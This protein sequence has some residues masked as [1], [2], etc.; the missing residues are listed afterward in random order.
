MELEDIL[1]F[2]G[3]VSSRIVWII[4]GSLF[5][6]FAVIFYTGL[7]TFPV[8]IVTALLLYRVRTKRD[9]STSPE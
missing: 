5:N 2:K 9:F 4:L 3:W 8:G 6:L 1:C 7:I